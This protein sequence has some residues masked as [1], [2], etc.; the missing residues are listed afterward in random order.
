[1]RKIKILFLFILLFLKPLVYGQVRSFN[2]DPTIFM[3]ELE[4]LF[5]GVEDKETLKDFAV[6]KENWL[7]GKFN[8]TQQKFMMQVS[9]DMLTNQMPV[10]PYFKLFYGSITR[11]LEKKMPDKTLA[12]WQ[13]VARN[14][15]SNSS[16]DYLEFLKTTEQLFASRTLFINENK[17]WFVDSNNYDI[18]L[19][20]GKVAL[21]FGDI[22]LTCK[23]LSDKIVIYKTKGIYY[24]GSSIWEGQYGTT[25]FSRAIPE[26]KTQIIFKKYTINFNKAQY[27]IDT[28]SLIYQKYFKEPILGKFADKLMFSLDS[29]TV[30]TGG[31]P[32][33]TSFKNNL[34]VRGIVGS[35]SFFR[36]GFSMNG[37]VINTS[38]V[39]NKPSFIDIFYKGKKRVTLKSTGFRI[40]NG[41]ASSSNIEFT[42]FLDSGK[43]ISHPSATVK[44]IFKENR[45][46]VTRG[47]DGLMRGSFADDYHNMS[48]DVEQVKWK[49]D[50][51]YVDFDNLNDDKAVKFESND[52]FRNMI[53]EKWQG[54]LKYN[55][56]EQLN[57]YYLRTPPDP[58]S[59]RME[60]EIKAMYSDKNAD[61]LIIQ[62]K[63][64]ELQDRRA[65]AKRAI[66]FKT[67]NKFTLDDFC[68]YFKVEPNNTK[69]L[70]IELHDAGFV[71]YN[72][73]NDSITINRKLFKYNLMHKKAVDYDV[74][75]LNSVIAA[76]PNATLNLLSNEM[77]IEG[78]RSCFF[79]D[80]Q[81]VSVKP[82]DQQVTLTS[83]RNLRFGGMVRA[84]RFDFYGQRFNF[85]YA[86][87]Q[88]DFANIDSM[89]MFFPDESGQRLIPIKSV[90]RNIGGTLFID[91]P[92]NKSGNINYPEYPI[93][94]SNKGSDILYDK[95]SIHGGQYKG[96]VFKFVVDPFTIDSLD[97]FTIQ[98][99]RFD[100]MFYSD[101]I[102]PD[103]RHYAYIQP[104]YSLG[105]VKQTP[106]GGYPM[107]RG[108]GKGE[109]TMNLSEMGFYGETGEINYETSVTK[110]DKI[111][112]LPKQAKGEVKSYDLVEN[113]KYPE[114][115]AVNASLNWLPYDDKYSITQGKTPI[116]MF[117]FG[118]DFEGMIT[119]SP[120]KVIGDGLLRWDLATFKSKEMVFSPKKAKVDVGELTIFTAD[121]TKIAFNSKNIHGSMDFAKRVGEFA[122]NETGQITNFPFNRY[123]TNLSDYKW[124]MDGQ[125]IEAR[126]GPGMG[127]ITPEFLSTNVLQ[128]SL[129]F[130]SPKAVYNLKDYT[131]KAERIPYIDI[132]DSRLFLKDG[133]VT[134]RENADMDELDSAKLIANRDDKFHEIYRLKIKVH[135][136]NRVRGSG[137]YQYVDKLAKR[138][139]F[140]LDSVIVNR[141]KHIE[142]IGKIEEEKGFTLD[143]KIGYKGLAQIE[144][145]EQLIKFMGFVK[146]LH[147]FANVLP[148]AW[149]QFKNYVDPKDV[150][151]PLSNPRDK[152]NTKQFVGLYIANDSSHVYP[153]MFSARRRYS[154]N[155]VSNDTGILY[156]DH[157]KESFMIGSEEKLRNGGTKG[158]FIQF[159][160]KDHSIHAEGP[161]DFGLESEH[162]KF[163]NAG[164]ADLKP[165]DSSFSFNLAMMLDFPLPEEFVKYLKSKIIDPEEPGTADLNTDFFKD[166]L[167]EMVAE[168]K[169]YRNIIQ[170][171]EKNNKLEG[172]AEANYKLILSDAT[173]RWDNKM[174]GMYCNDNVIVA[175]IAGEPVNKE[176][177]AVMLLESKRAGENMYV[178]LNYGD[179]YVFF[180]ISKNKCA[181]YASDP[182]LTEILVNNAEKIKAKDYYII[183][184]TERN[185]DKFLRKIER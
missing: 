105:F 57:V 10:L 177:K 6:F 55:P 54:P 181:I 22:T 83:N 63:L 31:Y 117:N 138:Q 125:T 68:A 78:V 41:V 145:H 25:D 130:E 152:M 172:K 111:L 28:V 95:P 108:K 169:V 146:P 164:H 182:K 155:D 47:E 118:Y 112:L 114:I 56:L 90:L 148:S 180:N 185:V 21:D 89:Q 79:S 128:D 77:N 97:N 20:K 184:T 59:D 12:Q 96:D 40:A 53:Y 127:G 62:S 51:P 165:G 174:R 48:I 29:N 64:K 170:G 46:V 171:I 42:L 129:K 143:K 73:K 69:H 49:I 120:S 132:A 109:M 154:D 32:K 66:D 175:S 16:E 124:D 71:N 104:D 150:V 80:S 99:L 82:F 65:A 3:Q 133:K 156:F 158:S 14:I 98:G 87:F 110:F 157:E 39:D 107:Y 136:R 179:D 70:F 115:H 43:T 2:A 61:K 126:V 139:E 121:S 101:G 23:S 72:F 4:G 76:K 93:F 19:I 141:A 18:K 34:L 167:G 30:K 162:I 92:N 81:N 149:L 100:G 27:E 163:K 137:Y 159:N 131:L 37:G 86:R 142:G 74:I 113:A 173:F 24:P 17:R 85:N 35:E 134:I 75:R 116:K 50:E 88:I 52:F 168:P 33:F 36:G 166:A 94:T 8:P 13:V 7:N 151:I 1:M 102:F 11:F 5:K 183:Q 9:N 135:G 67:R 58:V 38:T 60:K 140:L 45:L 91:K 176:M 15:L 161:M 103:F 106:N 144:S 26:D 119:Q 147:T 160:E 84:G 122:T 123:Q 44:F 153:L 178:Y